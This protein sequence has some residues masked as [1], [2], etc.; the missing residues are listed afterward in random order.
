MVA[1]VLSPNSYLLSAFAALLSVA[2]L[3]CANLRT[4]PQ[5]RKF[6]LER[7]WVRS[8]TNG[9]FLGFRRMNRMSPLLTES[10]LIQANS[11][12]GVVA[13]D[14]ATGSERWRLNIENGVEGGVV[15]SND[16]RLF[17]GANDGQF[18]SVQAE[19]G[20]VLWTFPVRAETLA[21]PSL[22][23]G[24][25]YFQSGADVIYSLDASS[26][27][28]IWTY[29][30]QTTTNLSIRSTTTPVVVGETLYTG[31]SDGFL[32]ALRKRDGGMIWERKLTRSQRFKDVDGTPV[33]DGDT[34]FVSSY[35]GAL[36]SLKR[37][38]GDIN[39]QVD[40]GGY[41]PVTLDKDVLYYASVTGQVM[42]LDKGS[43]KTIWANQLS[44]GIATQ[45]T[46]YRGYLL[47][48]ESEGALVVADAQTGRSINRF[49]PGRGLVSRPAVREDSGEVFFISNNANLYALKMG[50]RRWA[51]RLPWQRDP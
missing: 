18:Y 29:N 32:V 40:E 34:L 3:G 17:F 41:T 42:A 8:T 46:L 38:T 14:R 9:E 48:G 35:D 39:W 51:D 16:G 24:Q 36:Y 49:E 44:T 4:G 33:A 47:Y 10:L 45:P 21:A 7:N 30:R 15:L 26:G 12:D 22:D 5:P 13:F 31:F 25:I 37:E 6:V 2:L 23:G 20:K 28:Q 50:L 27:K 1:K 19:S 43:G 11:I